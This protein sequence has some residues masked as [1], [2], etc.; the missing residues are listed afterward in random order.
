MSQSSQ[1]SAEQLLVPRPPTPSL[2]A[3]LWKR[4]IRKMMYS[5]DQRDNLLAASLK[6]GYISRARLNWFR[7]SPTTERYNKGQREIERE[8]SESQK[9]ALLPFIS[10]V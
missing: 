7:R 9:I 2:R 5:S 3:E 10:F 4:N 8:H 1:Q 6:E